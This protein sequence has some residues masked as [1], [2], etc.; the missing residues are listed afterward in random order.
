MELRRREDEGPATSPPDARLQDRGADEL[1]TLVANPLHHGQRR[2]IR[3]LGERGAPRPR[4]W[5]PG[6]PLGQTHDVE[7]SL[8]TF[9]ADDPGGRD[10][11]G[12]VDQVVETV[13]LR[14]V[15]VR[16]VTLAP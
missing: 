11:R 13:L 3:R 5:R 1:S 4:P 2:R 10:C 7:L 9:G 16:T 12:Y 14:T 6:E 15:S 8:L